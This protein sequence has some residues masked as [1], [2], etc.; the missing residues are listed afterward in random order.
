[1]MGSTLPLVLAQE[2]S[3]LSEP[4][5][6][7]EFTLTDALLPIGVLL[8]VTWSLMTLR[9]RRKQMGQPP[10]AM[11]PVHRARVGQAANRMHDDLNQL[12]VEI[13][14]MAKRMGAQ[15][16]NK[17]A[18]IE[19]LLDEADRKLAELQQASRETAAPPSAASKPAALD[20]PE[21]PAAPA[22]P[23]LG[24]DVLNR[25]VCA[26]SDEGLSAQEIAEE[27]GEYIGKVELILSLRSA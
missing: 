17:A 23:T 2:V 7:A 6:F 16:D 11:E 14:Q 10:A 24:D 3:S 4:S 18:R 21:P 26:L 27:L 1:M 12:M 19:S 5:P 13:E 15:L 20:A 22:K 25:R 9:K 8:L